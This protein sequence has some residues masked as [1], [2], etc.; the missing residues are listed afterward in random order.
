MKSLN[1]YDCEIERFIETYNLMMFNSFQVYCAIIVMW[2]SVNSWS[3]YA[4]ENNTFSP[5]AS[6]YDPDIR[7]IWDFFSFSGS[8]RIRDH[9]KLNLPLRSVGQIL[10]WRHN[11]V[12]TCSLSEKSRISKSARSIVMFGINRSKIVWR[13]QKRQI[14]LFLSVRKISMTS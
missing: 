7:S 3:N 10:L 6:Q 5:A 14:C 8:S 13:I 4:N 12:R 11:D 1:W 2:W 9:K